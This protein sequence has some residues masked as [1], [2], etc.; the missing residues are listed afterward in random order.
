MI[1]FKIDCEI[2]VTLSLMIVQTFLTMVQVV[3]LLVSL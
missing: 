1:K 3:I 2:D